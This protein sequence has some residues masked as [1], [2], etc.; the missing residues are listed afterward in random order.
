[1]DR[2]V[3]SVSDSEH[4]NQLRQLSAEWNEQ[5]QRKRER[6]LIERVTGESGR[7][8]LGRPRK[9]PSS[10]TTTI[11][12]YG[13]N[14]VVNSDSPVLIASSPCDIEPNSSTNSNT[15]SESV[16]IPAN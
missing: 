16:C 1:M 15:R 6:E 2:F 14:V 12:N 7:R 10:T 8:R 3:H 13:G 4:Q 9:S 11:N 5:I